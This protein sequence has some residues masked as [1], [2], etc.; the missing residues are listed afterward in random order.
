MENKKNIYAN[1]IT[2]QL[3]SEFNDF[4]GSVSSAAVVARDNYLLYLS[5][6]DERDAVSFTA[7]S[8]VLRINLPLNLDA[9]FQN[10]FRNLQYFLHSIS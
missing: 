5:Y 6:T 10:F 7:Y 1:I 2:M 9:Q 3:I 4:T 8:R